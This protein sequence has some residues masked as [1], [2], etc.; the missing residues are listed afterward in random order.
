MSTEEEKAL[1]HRIQLRNRAR[2]KRLMNLQLKGNAAR[3]KA[4]HDAWAPRTKKTL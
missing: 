4:V 2:Y 3:A 1:L